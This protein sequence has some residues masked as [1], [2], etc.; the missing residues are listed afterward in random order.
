[1]HSFCFPGSR[2]TCSHS[3]VWLGCALSACYGVSCLK[4]VCLCST[5]HLR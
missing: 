5:R 3:N 2:L 1:V 4:R